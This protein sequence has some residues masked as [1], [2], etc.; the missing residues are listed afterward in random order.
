MKLNQLTSSPTTDATSA[1]LEAIPHA[2]FLLNSEHVY[3]Y[4]NTVAREEF[5][6]SGEP[7]KKH[8]FPEAVLSGNDFWSS[9]NTLQLAKNISGF[10]QDDGQHE[11]CIGHYHI[12]LVPT[13]L[14]GSRMVLVHFKK[15]GNVPDESDKSQ[16]SKQFTGNYHFL[17]NGSNDAIIL[18]DHATKKILDVNATTIDLLGYS[19]EEMLE[20]TTDVI[21][22]Q[23]TKKNSKVTKAIEA[24][25]SILF[26]RELIAKNGELIPCEINVSVV[27]Q[28]ERDITVAIIRDIRSRRKAEQTL[29]HREEKF[30]SLF[31]KVYD[32][33]LIVDRETRKILEANSSGAV[34]LG[35]APDELIGKNILDLY[36]EKN[37]ELISKQ[38]ER[39]ETMG[40][41]R[42][43][44]SQIR[45][46]GSEL[47]VSINGVAFTYDGKDAFQFY[48]RDITDTIRQERLI[49]ESESRFRQLT[50]TI[51]EAFWLT[52]WGNKQTLYVSPA[53]EHVYGRKPETLIENSKSWQ[54][55]VHPEDRD[56]V[57]KAF[58]ERA[59]AGNY[60]VQFR[61]VHSNGDVRWVHERAFPIFD[62]D[63]VTRLAGYSMDI[64]EMKVAQLKMEESEHKF[65]SL[66]EEAND[67]IYIISVEGGIFLKINRKG[68]DALGYA[69]GELIGTSADNIEIPFDPVKR[70]W[71]DKQLTDEGR[72]VYEH[73]HLKK[74]GTVIPVEVSA[75]IVEFEGQKVYQCQVRDITSRKV[76]EAELRKSYKEILFSK[77]LAEAAD[78]GATLS[79]LIHKIVEGLA[80]VIS[81]SALRLYSYNPSTRELSIEL[82]EIDQKVLKEIEKKSKVS[83]KSVVP[84]IKSN[85]FIRQLVEEREP[86]IISSKDD[87]KQF[88]EEHTSSKILQKLSPLVIRLLKVEVFVLLP[89]IYGDEVKGIVSFTLT[90]HPSPETMDS[91]VRHL[92]QANHILNKIKFEQE[93]KRSNAKYTDLIDNLKDAVISLDEDGQV[94]FSNHA[95]QNLFGY[96]RT[97]ILKV[98]VSDVI[99]PLDRIKSSRFYSKLKTSGFNSNYIGRIVTKFGETKYVEVSS[100]A[101]FD[102][103]GVFRGSRDI[104]R[105]I[106]VRKLQE[107]NKHVQQVLLENVAKG[108]EY[109]LI[110]QQALLSLEEVRSGDM[111]AAVYSY[112]R[113]DQKFQ[114]V[115]CNLKKQ[116]DFLNS[117]EFVGM[118]PSTL[119]D[120]N[121]KG[122]YARFTTSDETITSKYSH[123]G[124]A[125]PT[126]SRHLGIRGIIIV[127]FDTDKEV[128]SEE[129]DAIN[130]INNIL[131][132]SIE[133][134]QNKEE[135][136]RFTEN[137]EAAVERRTIEL[138]NEI[139]ERRMVEQ[140]LERSKNIAESASKAKSSFLAN[141]SHE[142]RSPLNAI[143]GFSQILKGIATR[144]GLSAKSRSFLDNIEMSSKNL[145]AIINDILDLSKIESGK[146]ELFTEDFELEQIVKNVYHINKS[147]AKEKNINFNYTIDES[148]PTYIHGDRTKLMQ[149]IMNLTSNAIKFTPDEKGVMIKVSKEKDRLIILV[150]DEGIGIDEKRLAKIFE[151]FEQED[152]SV[153]R[154]FGGSGLGLAI[155]NSIVELMGGNISVDSEKLKGSSFKID[156]PLHPANP[157]HNLRA[158]PAYDFNQIDFGDDFKIV[159]VEDNLLNQ[160][161]VKS[162]MEQ[163]NITLITADNGLDGIRQIK[164]HKPNVVLMD[165]HMPVMDGL[166]TIRRIQSDDEISN[167]PIV[168][169]SADAF[170]ETREKAYRHG[171][172]E[173]LT[174]PLDLN[175]LMETLEKLN[176]TR[177]SELEF[178]YS[179][180]QKDE[181]Q[182]LVVSDND[183][184]VIDNHI[185]NMLNIPIFEAEKLLNELEDLKAYASSKEI[186]LNGKERSI[187][188]AIFAGNEQELETQLSNL[189]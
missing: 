170:A 39:L 97:E 86:V 143:L 7:G 93:L 129:I 61:V 66:F 110:V 169:Y 85:S 16:S 63:K 83:T 130:S 15:S 116:E 140:E 168:G 117:I 21:C 91:L 133:H 13:E 175:K 80:E 139:F 122:D 155:S 78:K 26:E 35:Y 51:Q 121:T 70:E 46:D 84:T 27:N 156:L 67:P 160:D 108:V 56:W 10:N 95:A 138:R 178:G 172:V 107:R 166:E 55:W 32:G 57:I 185:Q 22:S 6:V 12:S 9:E 163:I 40:E 187:E 173:Y 162:L 127:F 132:I 47:H 8:R 60:D 19:L 118:Y 18:S 34:R 142:I 75:H 49:R 174:K 96:S 2:V 177:P 99:H 52:D 30:R 102:E 53:Y 88:I 79:Y 188:D 82:E 68:C 179:E 111:L 167:I 48:I 171:V 103:N 31:E 44:S 94:I 148:L 92:Q 29:A 165:M 119:I 145:S 73:A 164:K 136:Q 77:N 81:P 120:E 128:S 147:A 20:M 59:E 11:L 186:N 153:T 89:I 62:N 181:T 104:V 25:R 113:T 137:L 71:I 115:G 24:G 36:P 74:D 33:I 54:E 123:I 3:L 124:Y 141:M 65:K 154:E 152:T 43:K 101:V 76:A 38:I 28:P 17:F 109:E 106:T 64:T 184:K 37:L 105:D 189:I 151:P 41:V 161:V 45:K 112:N 69:R 23:L 126:V 134:H 149:V 100:T 158:T 5:K 125:F 42:F 146:L 176:R 58:Y 159:L 114:M 144:E 150:E 50:E 182:P 90:K 4:C 157:N 1:I 131:K 135:I 72:V 14:E 183:R 87:C 180:D 98:K